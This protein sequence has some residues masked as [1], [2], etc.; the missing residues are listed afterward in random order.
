MKWKFQHPDW[1]KLVHKCKKNF[2]LEKKGNFYVL[3][4][5]LKKNFLTLHENVCTFVNNSGQHP[6]STSTITNF[7][8]IK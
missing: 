2:K 3:N 5:H 7:N 4:L 8:T 6:A 1:F